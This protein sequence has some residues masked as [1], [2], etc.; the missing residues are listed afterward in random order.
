MTVNRLGWRDRERQI[1]KPEGVF[2][3][4]LV[5]SS[6]VMGCGIEDDRTIS[7]VLEDRLNADPKWNRRRFEVLNFG[8]GRY[9]TVH[10]RALIERKVLTFDP[11]LIIFVVHQDELFHNA[12]WVATAVTKGIDLEDSCLDNIVNDSGIRPGDSE[13]VIAT[14]LG[15][16]NVPI[17]RCTYSRIVETCRSEGVPITYVYLPLPSD[18][19]TPA[20]PR[21]AIQLAQEAGLPTIDLSGW[22]EGRPNE[23]VI[24][25]FDDFHPNRLGYE[26]IAERLYRQITEIPVLRDLH[27]AEGGAATR[28]A[29]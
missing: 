20:D 15:R 5:G 13:G 11:D 18:R 17:L 16:F 4:A 7:R 29:P 27:T 22:W 26:L 14:S 19:P 3:I 28:A 6:V 1:N 8:M 2:R 9:L 10:R 23:Q 12:N 24:G 25:K 21:I